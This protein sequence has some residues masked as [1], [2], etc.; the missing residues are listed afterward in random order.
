ML[1]A[2]DDKTREAMDVMRQQAAYYKIDIDP[3][4]T[5]EELAQKILDAQV[6]VKAKA[7]KDFAAAKK[8]KVLMKRDGWPLEDMKV[9]AGNTCDVPS[10]MARRWIELGVAER[11][12]PLPEL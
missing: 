2:D 7:D 3:V 8:V 11:A 10:D 12:D 5:P 6:A 1:M 4:W 9:P